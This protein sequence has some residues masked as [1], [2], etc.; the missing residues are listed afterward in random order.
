MLQNFERD[1]GVLFDESVIAIAGV[2]QTGK[3]IYHFLGSGFIIGPSL[4]VTA[5]HVIDGFM[6]S[7]YKNGMD[8]PNNFLFMPERS[9]FHLLAWQGKET[10]LL[11][12]AFLVDLVSVSNFSDFAVLRLVPQFDMS[13]YLWRP[14]F[15]T[16]MLPNVGSVVTGFGYRVECHIEEGIEKYISNRYFSNG[17]VKDIHD[18]QRDSSTINFPSFETNARYEGGMSGGPVFSQGHYVVGL[19][20]SSMKLPQSDQHQL[21]EYYSHAATIWPL[22]GNMIEITIPSISI[23]PGYY[24]IQHLAALGVVKIAG[25]EDFTIHYGDDG[26]PAGIHYWNPEK[27]PRKKAAWE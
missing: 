24:T 7:F 3:G 13:S 19:I 15:L 6:S 23:I 25:H 26:F 17:I 12:R 18:L 4:A 10:D 16:T 22:L 21:E 20:S 11:G 8:I 1:D 9:K 27:Y 14:Y 5:R 2:S